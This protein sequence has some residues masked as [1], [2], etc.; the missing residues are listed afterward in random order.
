MCSKNYVKRMASGYAYA[1]M[2]TM[3]NVMLSQS[4]CDNAK[5]MGIV[6]ESPRGELY[7]RFRV[8]GKDYYQTLVSCE[9]TKARAFGDDDVTDGEFPRI[10]CDRSELIDLPL[11]HHTQ[12]LQQTASGYGSKL[13]NPFCIWF[14][15]KVYRLYTTIFSNAGST[16]FIANGRK[17]YVD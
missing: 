9:D 10:Y 12:G 13:A 1:S 14:K 17:I 3:E 2:K 15:G 4:D 7:C 16:W 6:R 8:N 5:F 11:W